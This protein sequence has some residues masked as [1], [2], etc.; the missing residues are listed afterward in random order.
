[1]GKLL[2]QILS[3]G[4]GLCLSVAAF[5]TPA[6][7]L[8]SLLDGMHSLSGKFSQ[9]V[10]DSEGVVQ[11]ESAGEFALQRPGKFYWN[12]QSPMAQLLVSNGATI[13]LYDPDLETV[14]QREFTDDLRQTPALLLSEDA[15]K[16]NEN[17]VITQ[18]DLGAGRVQFVLVP[19]DPEGLFNDLT[20]VFNK[21]Q[22]VQFAIADAMGQTTRCQLSEVQR[23]PSLDAKQF[24]FVIPAGAEVITN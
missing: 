1:M 10:V 15:G 6:E 17:F 22:L 23:N 16:L 4:A 9:T 21:G 3:V 7:S 12:T 14:N 11:D 8:R 24:N 18:Q 20:L 13:W 2:Q 19:K 5:A